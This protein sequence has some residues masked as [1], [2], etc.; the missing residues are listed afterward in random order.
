MKTKILMLCIVIMAAT[1]LA[2]S[3]S[4]Q[5][6]ADQLYQSAIYKED[7]EGQLEEAIAAYQEI[8]KKFPDEDPVA[9]KAWFHMGLCYEKLGNQE[10]QKAYQH[11]L[12]NYADQKKIASQARA[13]LAVLV[14]A[15]KAVYVDDGCARVRGAPAA[16]PERDYARS[17]RG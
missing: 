13:R 16:R 3:G 8:I 12:S 14:K 11:V 1:A 17:S 10:A 6:S 5:Q 9:A 7:V 15:A 4:M 2:L